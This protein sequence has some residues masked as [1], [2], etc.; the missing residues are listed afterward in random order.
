[1][2]I[3]K[4]LVI[5]LVLITLA[6]S[7]NAQDDTAM[8]NSGSSDDTDDDDSD[9]VDDDT[10]DDNKRVRIRE[11]TEIKDGE[12]RTLKRVRDAD[13]NEIRER[14]RIKLSDGELRER[15]D[16]KLK[17]RESDIK[18]RLDRINVGDLA[19]LNIENVQCQNTENVRDRVK[20]RIDIKIRDTGRAEI[21]EEFKLN[22]LPEECRVRE[23]ETE[24]K[25]CVKRYSSVQKCWM[26]GKSEIDSCIKEQLDAPRSKAEIKTRVGECKALEGED[27][28]TCSKEIRTKVHHLI[29]F[30]LHKLE[31]K[32]ARFLDRGRVDEEIY[33]DFITHLEL[34]K[35]DFAESETKEEKRQIILDVKDLWKDFVSNV[36]EENEEVEDEN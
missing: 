17:T 26:L 3:S 19:G 12:I 8:D 20:C 29:K 10:D 4:L 1:M 23:D 2:K 25:E 18:I 28:K 15:F 21:R 24:R 11:K 7:V 30:R 16:K 31:E 36:V 32:A 27:K 9:D 33:V 6:I 22:Y 5:F 13:G 35:T 34:K 14:T